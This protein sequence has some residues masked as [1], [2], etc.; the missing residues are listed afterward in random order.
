MSYGSGGPS[1][2]PLQETSPKFLFGARYFCSDDQRQYTYTKVGRAI[3]TSQQ[4]SVSG[5]WLH[6]PLWCYSHVR[7]SNYRWEYKNR[8]IE[9]CIDSCEICA[10]RKGNYGKCRHWPTGHCKRGKRPFQCPSRRENVISS[11][12]LTALAAVSRPYLARETVQLTPLED[13]TASSFASGK[14]HESYLLTVEPTSQG[15]C[16]KTSATWYQSLESYI[17]PGEHRT[18]KNALFMLREDRNCE[19]TDILESVKSMNETINSATGV[20]PHYVITGRQPN[21]GLPKLLHSEPTNQSPTAYG[22]Q[23]NALLRQIRQRI[24]L[25]NHE[26]FTSWM[27]NWTNS[28]TRIQYKWATRCYYTALN[29]LLHTHPTW[30]GSSRSKSSKQTTWW[31]R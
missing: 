18:M 1:N 6:Q 24:A 10:K 15:K 23:I 27:R 12:S 4:I 2:T 26:Q 30:I 22:M 14:Y 25:A 17:G 8:D 13:F 7:P 21:I 19:W 9:V 16:I 5:A 29:L 31:F 20:S 11:P 28:Y 3:Q